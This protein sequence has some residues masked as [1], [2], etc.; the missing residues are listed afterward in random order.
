M[1]PGGG[2]SIN[3]QGLTGSLST[4]EGEIVRVSEI[5]N[6]Q[7]LDLAFSYHDAAETLAAT[8]ANAIPIINLRCHAIELFLK[9]LHLEDTAT[10][11]E[12]GV[13]LSRPKSGRGVR[14][15]LKDSLAMAQEPHRQELLSGMISLDD[16]L[17]SLEGI[18][19]KSRYLYEDGSSLPLST[20]E[21]TCRYLAET[22]PHLPHLAR[23]AK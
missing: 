14:H 11:L 10:A 22:V 21:R 15:D 6:P 2:Y 12:D 19:Q 3:A 4:L 5:P 7:V 18:F 13:Y 23:V 20:A 16:D 9:S 1:P 17:D 8:A